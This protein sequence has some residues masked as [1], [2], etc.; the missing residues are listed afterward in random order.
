[1]ALMQAGAF[2]SPAELAAYLQIPVQTVYRWNYAGEGPKALKIGR[3]LR[4][5]RD[6][7]ERWLENREKG[8]TAA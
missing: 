1:M 5:R 3:H 7:V 8:G 4:Y 2:L 6:D